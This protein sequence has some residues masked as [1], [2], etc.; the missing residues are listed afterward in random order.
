MHTC[1][2]RMISANVIVW[3]AK[4]PLH[5]DRVG[6]SVAWDEA[7]LRCVIPECG[8]LGCSA[9]WTHLVVPVADAR[10]MITQHMIRL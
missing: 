5:A 2:C 4:E 7:Q 1:V 8:G 10:A 9:A 6:S 3:T